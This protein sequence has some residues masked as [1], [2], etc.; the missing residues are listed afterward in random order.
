ML[1]GNYISVYVIWKLYICLCYTETIYLFMLYENYMSVY[2]IWKLYICLC[3]METIYLFMLYGNYIYMCM[4]YGNYI[5]IYVTWKLYIC[6][7]IS[8][9]SNTHFIL[10]FNHVSVSSFEFGPYIYHVQFSLGHHVHEF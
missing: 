5:S 7:L 2:V 9:F 10:L 8:Y 3:Y 4:L 1:Y 6:L